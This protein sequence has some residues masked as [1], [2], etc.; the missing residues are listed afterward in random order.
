MLDISLK[1]PNV[2][3]R[4]KCADMSKPN[5]KIK[6]MSPYNSMQMSAQR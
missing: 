3:F 6:M 4:H 2:G 1:V 5:V